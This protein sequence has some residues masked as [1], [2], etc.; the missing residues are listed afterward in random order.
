M[1][2]NVVSEAA[3]GLIQSFLLNAMASS[4]KAADDDESDADASEDECEL[5]P[6]KP[7]CQK[8]HELLRSG[9]RSLGEKWTAAAKAKAKA[10]ETCRAKRGAR[11][12]EYERSHRI[13][14]RERERE[15]M[16]DR[17]VELRSRRANEPGQHVR[18][19]TPGPFGG[20]D[21]ARQREGCARSPFR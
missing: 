3:A 8:F 15:S 17:P 11:L 18:G 12:Q 21:C 4:G 6:L 2:G 9:E 13:G 1:R 20:I 5:P 19:I 7:P 10:S 14:E 16:E